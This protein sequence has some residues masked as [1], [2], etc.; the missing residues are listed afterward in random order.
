MKRDKKIVIIIPAKGTSKRIPGKN[1]KEL[2]G[3]PMMAYIIETALEVQKAC[4]AVDRVIV[5]TD[6]QEVKAVAEKYGAEVPFI[7]PEHLTLD[8][9][10]TRDVLQ[11][12]L[13]VLEETEG[14]ISDYVLLLYPTSPLL[15]MAKIKEAI[16]LALERDS[17]SVFSATV[18]KGHY[19]IEVEGGWNRLYPI[20]QVNSQYQIPLAKEN[21]AIY[22]T[23]SQFISKQYVADKADVVFMEEEDSIDVDYPEDFVRVEKILLEK[24]KDQKEVS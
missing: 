22:L 24:G 11:H 23:K 9:V 4:P 7:R 12:T 20:K 5:S 17:D 8:A 16:E 14:Y 10:P 15:A 6:S 18:D 2:V 1:L 19:W 21:G 3:K 13:D